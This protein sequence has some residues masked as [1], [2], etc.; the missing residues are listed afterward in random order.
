MFKLEHANVHAKVMSFLSDE[1]VINEVVID[2]PE[3]T[4]ELSKGKANWTV[5]LEHLDRKASE[6]TEEEPGEKKKM[7]IDHITFKNGKIHLAGIPIGQT[8]NR[9]TTE[10]R[11]T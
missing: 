11:A 7:R 1:I 9:A 5:L 3:I 6:K 10:G 4:L 8:G 2:G